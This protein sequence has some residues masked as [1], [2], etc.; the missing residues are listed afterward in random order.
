MVQLC[1][2]SFFEKI[3]DIFVLYQESI[4]FSCLNVLLFGVLLVFLFC[5]RFFSQLYFVHHILFVTPII[6][7]SRFLSIKVNSNRDYQEISKMPTTIQSSN[8]NRGSQ[9][10]VHSS[11]SLFFVRY[12]WC[13]Q[14]AYV[15]IPHLNI[16]SEGGG[17]IKIQLSVEF[18][19]EFG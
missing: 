1:K 3:L 10:Y 13:E 17:G 15:M 5:L 11:G 18:S 4:S 6:Q 9:K 8:Y 16:K 19:V 2:I 12:I 14:Y 7:C